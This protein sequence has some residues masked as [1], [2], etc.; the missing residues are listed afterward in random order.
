VSTSEEGK[1]LFNKHDEPMWDLKKNKRS[2][3]ALGKRLN[4]WNQ[5][6]APWDCVRSLPKM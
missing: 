1:V 4:F 3:E 6:S 2:G 5:G